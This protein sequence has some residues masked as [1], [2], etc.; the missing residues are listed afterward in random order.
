[1]FSQANLELKPSIRVAI[2]L[3]IPCIATLIL[4]LAAQIPFIISLLLVC[5]HLSLSYKFITKFA[6]LSSTSSIKFIQANKQTIY[7][8]DKCGRCYI[9]K[10][11]GNK[12]LHPAFTLLSFDCEKSKENSGQVEVIPDEL[13]ANTGKSTEIISSS[14]INQK[15]IF[16]QKLRCYTQNFIRGIIILKNRRH[17]IICRYNAVNSSDFRRIRVWF[18]F[19]V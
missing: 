19:K 16:P 1:M 7:L 9:A 11:L 10:S 14:I 2:L 5:I 15:S 13:T 12:T 4:I 18:R 8:K 17:L 3:S 6:L